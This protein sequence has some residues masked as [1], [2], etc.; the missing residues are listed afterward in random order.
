[1]AGATEVTAELIGLGVT[2]LMMMPR[3]ENTGGSTIRGKL[4][5]LAATTL[6]SL[7]QEP[8]LHFAKTR[9]ASYLGKQPPSP[10]QDKIA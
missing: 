7:F 5:G 3:K 8:V 6:W 9:F 4:A 10:D 2:R 1:M